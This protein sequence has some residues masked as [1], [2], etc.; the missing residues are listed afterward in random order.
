M[1]GAAPGIAG[2]FSRRDGSSSAMPKRKI[3]VASDCAGLEPLTASCEL[4]GFTHESPVSDNAFCET[5]PLR[6]VGI[7]HELLY[8]SEANKPLLQRLVQVNKPVTAVDNALDPMRPLLA[9][10]SSVALAASAVPSAPW[11]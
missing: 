5:S 8:V 6:L 9:S 1:P 7:R 4:F 11:H 10:N 3:V 2:A